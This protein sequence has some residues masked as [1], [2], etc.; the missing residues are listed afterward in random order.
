M[1][2]AASSRRHLLALALMAGV[3]VW[4]AAGGGKSASQKYDAPV[5]DVTQAKALIDAGATVIDVRGREQFDVRH[6]P[7]AILVPL[8][9]LHAGIPQSLE[10]AKNKPIVVYCNDGVRTGPEATHV[11]RQAGFTNAVNLKTGIEGWT[12]AGLPVA[13]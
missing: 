7:G 4:F 8:A 13:K 10:A 12:G 6:I 1:I 5:V 2:F 11:L 9:A 3:T